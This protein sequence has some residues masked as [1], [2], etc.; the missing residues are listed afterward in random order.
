L[1]N[2][3]VLS[4][5]MKMSCVGVCVVQSSLAEGMTGVKTTDPVPLTAYI[6]AALSGLN[7]VTGVSRGDDNDDN[8]DDEEEED[9]DDDEDDDD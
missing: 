9:N 1:G 4:W 7:D 3:D 6:L 2:K 5:V 8:Y